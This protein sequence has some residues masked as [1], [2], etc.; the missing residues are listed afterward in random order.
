MPPEYT[1]PKGG[2]ATSQK[3]KGGTIGQAFPS[4][5]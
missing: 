4:D 5:F 3:A 2:R 1:T